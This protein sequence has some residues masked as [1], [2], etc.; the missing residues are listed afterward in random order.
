MVHYQWQL[1]SGAAKR[2]TGLQS[3]LGDPSH[4]LGEDTCVFKA[5]PSRGFPT[6]LHL[7]LTLDPLH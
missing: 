7:L 2:A 6:C 4:G 5:R 1:V 3:I